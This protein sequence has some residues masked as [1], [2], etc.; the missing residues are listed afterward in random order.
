MKYIFLTFIALCLS[1][2]IMGCAGFTKSYK[3]SSKSKEERLTLID[4]KVGEIEQAISNLNASS[5]NLERRFEELS[6]KTA[7]TDAN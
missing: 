1:S 4:Q 6:Q 7:N 5:Q 3:K 2:L